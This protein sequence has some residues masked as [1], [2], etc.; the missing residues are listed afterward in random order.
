MLQSWFAI[1]SR[2]ALS[3][4]HEKLQKIMR[5]CVILHN[6]IVEDERSEPHDYMYERAT[7]SNTTCATTKDSDLSLFIRNYRAMRDSQ[8]HFQLRD[9][10]IAHLWARKGEMECSS[11]EDE[12]E[13]QVIA[14]PVDDEEEDYQTGSSSQ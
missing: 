3:W 5:T 9:D 12:E 14:P 13:E 7:P 11:D 2:P 4:T 8:Q 10:L 6:M 1:V